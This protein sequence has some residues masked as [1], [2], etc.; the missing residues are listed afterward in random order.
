MRQSVLLAL[1]WLA[2]LLC[3]TARP[4]Q[5]QS[6]APAGEWRTYGGDLASTRYAPLDE[7]T[8]G[9]FAALELAWRFNQD[10][11]G[12]PAGGRATMSRPRGAAGW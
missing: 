10:E 11:L 9:N 8:A 5:G 2:V 3:C 7:I 6:G 1:V 4:A 12:P